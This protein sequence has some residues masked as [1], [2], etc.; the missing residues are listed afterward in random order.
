MSSYFDTLRVETAE[1]FGEEDFIEKL[2]DLEEKVIKEV[3]LVTGD[4]EFPE[5]L[6][7]KIQTLIATK[8]M[9]WIGGEMNGDA[10]AFAKAV[11]YSELIS[12]L[13]SAFHAV[14]S[15]RIKTR[16]GTLTDS[17]SGNLIMR[18]HHDEGIEL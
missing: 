10:I 1:I 4:R 15:K 2:I 13:H 12:D 18:Q 8:R 3:N 9:Q 6:R 5:D 7:E 14:A 17:P 16:F 11:G